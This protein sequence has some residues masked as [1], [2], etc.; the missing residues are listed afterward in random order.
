MPR[1][2]LGGPR[3]LLS[4]ECFLVVNE[5]TA[6][7]T[8][9][10]SGGTSPDRSDE[11]RQAAA[12]H[13]PVERFATEPHPMQPDLFGDVLVAE[14]DN[15]R[16]RLNRY[17]AFVSEYASLTGTDDLRVISTGLDAQTKVDIQFPRPLVEPDVEALL[18]FEITHSG[19]DMEAV[20]SELESE[21]GWITGYEVPTSGVAILQH[22][23]GS[24]DLVMA[25]I[26]ELMEELNR[27]AIGGGDVTVACSVIE[28]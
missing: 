2:P 7:P 23:G 20:A 13:L 15:D 27:T 4:V 6:L 21:F 3:P 19:A 22:V 28:S 5:Y 8:E 1:G 11:F 16:L 25:Q 12:E 18:K 17:M 10:I 26:L 24:N 9:T 14:L